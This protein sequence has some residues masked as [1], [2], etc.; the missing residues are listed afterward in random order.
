MAA[1]ARAPRLYGIDRIE[2]RRRARANTQNEARHHRIG[3]HD[4]GHVG[5]A[6]VRG[7]LRRSRT[8]RHSDH[9]M[10]RGRGY[11]SATQ[12]VY[13]IRAQA[14]RVRR[15]ARNA[16]ADVG[17]ALLLLRLTTALQRQTDSTTSAPTFAIAALLRA[18]SPAVPVK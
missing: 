9:S 3:L 10:Q 16:Q 4:A 2:W 12:S 14:D 18:A 7:A 6:T 1:A 13:R 17:V 15:V 8:A 5:A 11:S